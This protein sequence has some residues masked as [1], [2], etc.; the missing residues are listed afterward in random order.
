MQAVHTSAVWLGAVGE[1]DG[2]C[3]MVVH[4]CR[5]RRDC[6]NNRPGVM[7]RTSRRST[8]DNLLSLNS[9]GSWTL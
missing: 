2:D 1:Q 7:V 5:G 6:I 8:S 3:N 4:A 9:R